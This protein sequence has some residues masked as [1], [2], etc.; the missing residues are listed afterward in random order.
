MHLEQAEQLSP[1]V[2]A[3]FSFRPGI[4][5]FQ[6][7]WMRSVDG[8]EQ[9]LEVGALVADVGCGRGESTVRMARAFPKSRFIGVEEDAAALEAARNLA[10]GVGLRNVLFL[11][12]GAADL[13]C[14]DLF[15]VIASYDSIHRLAD[16]IAAAERI[17]ATLADNGVWLWTAP[18]SFG[19]AYEIA[20]AAGF[21]GF[22]RLTAAE[23]SHQLFAVRK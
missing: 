12:A 14:L 22:E 10:A 16:P 21:G 8:L 23:P 17:F 15:D 6:P 5:C 2:A 13:P 19:Q 4:P 9:T 18:A 7:D 11:Q 1:P 20:A 3:G